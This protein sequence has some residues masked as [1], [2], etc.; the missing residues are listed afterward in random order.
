MATFFCNTF[1]SER[2]KGKKSDDGI[3]FKIEKVRSKTDKENFH[4]RRTLEA[5]ASNVRSNEFIN[6]SKSEHNGAGTKRYGHTLEQLCRKRSRR[7]ARP[8]FLSG[9]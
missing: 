8:K 5:G 3:Y 7:S 2:I 4:A 9:R 1:I 6:D